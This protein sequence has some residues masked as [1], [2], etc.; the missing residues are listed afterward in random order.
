MGAPYPR[1]SSVPPTPVSIPPSPGFATGKGRAMNR[2]YTSH[3][4]QNN[5]GKCHSNTMSSL[6]VFI[7]RG[8]HAISKSLAHLVE[9]I[10]IPLDS[11]AIYKGHRV[12][13][14]ATWV[15]INSRI[16]RA[17]DYREFNQ[18]C[19]ARRIETYFT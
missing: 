19:L 13:I 4:D 9:R 10:F 11:I 16:Y 1:G 8:Q 18:K 12:H 6:R 15:R 17:F 5:C 2:N 14:P 3:C 7:L